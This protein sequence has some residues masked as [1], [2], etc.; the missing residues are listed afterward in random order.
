MNRSAGAPSV[1]LSEAQKWDYV[2]AE[3]GAS[4]GL[5][6]S[7]PSLTAGFLEEAETL[8]AV[9]FLH[10]NNLFK[11]LPMACIILLAFWKG[12]FMVSLGGIYLDNSMLLVQETLAVSREEAKMP[13]PGLEEGT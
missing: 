12:S 4:S 7:K 3:A 13:A 2:S 11:C 6:K 5:W 10:F 1:T 8:R 9:S